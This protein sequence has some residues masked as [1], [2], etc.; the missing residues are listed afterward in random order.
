MNHEG[1]SQ[2]VWLRR[3]GSDAVVLVE[4]AKGWVEVIRESLAGWPEIE[5]SHIKERSE[6]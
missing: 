3:E 5:F 2:A 6:P 1:V 4:T